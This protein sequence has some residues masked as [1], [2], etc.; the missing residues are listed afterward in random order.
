M[1]KSEYH[2]KNSNNGW[3]DDKEKNAGHFQPRIMEL[4]KMFKVVGKMI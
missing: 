4:K 1:K 3:K 2:S